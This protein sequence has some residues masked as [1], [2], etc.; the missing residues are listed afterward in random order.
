MIS[1]YEHILISAAVCAGQENIYC[2]TYLQIYR[3]TIADAVRSLQK[4]DD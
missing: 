1:D 3:E 2:R 4:F